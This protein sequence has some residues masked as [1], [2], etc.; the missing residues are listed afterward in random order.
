ME[1]TGGQMRGRDW[2]K[3]V[4]AW[5]V[6]VEGLSGSVAGEEEQQRPEFGGLFKHGGQFRVGR[7]PMQGAAGN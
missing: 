6:S 4:D 3:N 7:G 1:A 2:T 5:A